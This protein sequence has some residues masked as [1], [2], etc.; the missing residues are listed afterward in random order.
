V[1]RGPETAA[2]LTITGGNDNQAALLL[3]NGNDSRSGV[4]G[5]AEDLLYG[6]NGNDSLSGL[7]GADTLYGGNG[8]D[9]LDGGTGI[10]W[11]YGERGDDRI[12]TGLGADVVVLSASGG[13]DTV[14]DFLVGTDH[15][16]LEGVSASSAALADVDHNGG[17]NDL[18]IQ[19]TNGSVTLLNTGAVANWQT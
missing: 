19:L 9:T 1:L 6:Q 3:G 4:A 14:L 10:D 17:A 18:V 7:G 12:T 5:E 11:L 8:A 16:H 15:L 2:R 13:A